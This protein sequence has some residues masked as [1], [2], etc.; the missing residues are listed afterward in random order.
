MVERAI[1]EYE[2]LFFLTCFVLISQTYYFYYLYSLLL[3]CHHLIKKKNWTVRERYFAI[4][5]IASGPQ[6]MYQGTAL[7]TPNF[8]DFHIIFSVIF[9]SSVEGDSPDP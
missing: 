2:I 6:G 4:K 3:Y 7:W 5:V 1:K 8:Y 9:N